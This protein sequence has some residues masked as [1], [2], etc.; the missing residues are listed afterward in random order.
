MA[1]KRITA[2]LKLPN[3]HTTSFRFQMAREWQ[4]KLRDEIL[5]HYPAS[6]NIRF[7]ER[8]PERGLAAGKTFETNVMFEIRKNYFVLGRLH[9]ES[10]NT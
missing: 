3:G 9:L 6:D 5:T 10:G 4:S 8:L 2:S 1:N 7:V